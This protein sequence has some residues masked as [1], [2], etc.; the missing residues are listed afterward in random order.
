ML[1]VSCGTKYVK[2]N[3]GVSRKVDVESWWPRRQT[4]PPSGQGARRSPRAVHWGY[5]ACQWSLRSLI[6]VGTTCSALSDTA[7]LA[8]ALIPH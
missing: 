4:E 6:P 3:E 5:E 1:V 8:Q 2:G 7:A